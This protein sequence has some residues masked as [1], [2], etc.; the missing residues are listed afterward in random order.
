L[1]ALRARTITGFDHEPSG[2][3]IS[4]FTVSFLDALRMNLQC[5]PYVGVP[6]SL[7]RRLWVDASGDKGCT[8]GPP[9][10]VKAR[11]AT[12]L[13][14]PY[15]LNSRQPNPT[16]PVVLLEHPTTGGHEHK[17]LIIGGRQSSSGKVSRQDIHQWVRNSNRTMTRVGLGAR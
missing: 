7:L 13:I 11:A 12:A 16:P 1:G 15:R 4:G 6:K 5:R 17:L 10:V 3:D 8:D 9:K 2:E 14:E